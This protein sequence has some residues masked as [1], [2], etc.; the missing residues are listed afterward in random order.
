MGLD[1]RYVQMFADDWKRHH[2]Y[3]CFKKIPQLQVERTS[4]YVSKYITKM[5]DLDNPLIQDGKVQKPRKL[6]SIGYGMP[7]KKRF[8]ALRRDVL[9]KLA[10]VDMEN[11]FEADMSPQELKKNIELVSK[12]L[13]YH[14]NGKEYKLPAWYRRKMLY[15][16]DPL[17][18]KARQSAL[19]NMVSKAVQ[20]RIQKDFAGE[21]IKLAYQYSLPE[22]DQVRAIVSKNL[23][24]SEERQRQ[25]RAQVI[26]ETNIAALRKSKF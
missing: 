6:T 24:R 20:D 7:T 10:D 12:K 21:L 2:G 3:V 8:D 23:C 11:P 18:G 22:S 25:D 13:K 16:K 14:L 19:S 9:G 15:V 1:D 5:K 26:F 17:T 4:R